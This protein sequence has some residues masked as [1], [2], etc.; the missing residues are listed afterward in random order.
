M[1]RYCF[2]TYGIEGGHAPTESIQSVNIASGVP[3]ASLNAKLH[4]VI[5][6]YIPYVNQCYMDSQWLE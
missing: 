4:T 6:G 5:S 2:V 3:R 1:S